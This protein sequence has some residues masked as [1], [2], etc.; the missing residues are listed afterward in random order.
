M[1]NPFRDDPDSAP[2]F[3]PDPDPDSAPDPEPDR[4][5]LPSEV[6]RLYRLSRLRD[7]LRDDR[8]R[9]PLDRIRIASTTSTIPPSATMA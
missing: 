8:F 7:D 5:S 6:S 1:A 3:D 4:P 2:D 9:P